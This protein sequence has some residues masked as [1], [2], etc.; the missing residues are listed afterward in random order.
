MLSQSLELIDIVWPDGKKRK[1]VPYSCTY[2]GTW[3]FPPEEPPD[4]RLSMLLIGLFSSA[5]AVG[6]QFKNTI[7]RIGSF[8]YFLLFSVVTSFIGIAHAF[9]WF[10][11]LSSLHPNGNTLVSGPQIVLWIPLC[12][13]VLKN[14]T[15]PL[16]LKWPLL[17][18]SLCAIVYALYELTI[19]LQDNTAQLALWIPIHITLLVLLLKRSDDRKN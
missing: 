15:C 4:H 14:K 2:D 18:S 17:F 6:M 11:A 10:S 7:L 1:L 9:L 19:G 5:T 13:F 8:S 12:W 16:I 3:G